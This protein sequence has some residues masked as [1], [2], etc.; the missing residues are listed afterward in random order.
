MV[1]MVT[2]NPSIARNTPM[3]SL[4]CRGSNFFS[5][6]RRSFSL[7]ARIIARMCGKRSSAK[8]MC[9]VRQS[10]MPSAPNARAWMASRGMSAFARTPRVR[11]GS[12]QPMN[13]SSSGSSG[14]G[15]S[16]FSW[17]LITRPVVPSSEIQ[18]PS[19]NTWP[20]TRIS[21]F[22]SST[23]MSPAPATQHFPMPRV[24]TAAWLVMPPR[25]VRMP[26]ATSMPWMSSGVV[27]ARTRM[28]GIFLPWPPSRLLRQR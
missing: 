20:L 1:R 10:P 22:F 17:P 15:G 19:L 11:N 3:K 16:V 5:A 28:T 13:L 24:T 25:E 27:S 18:S 14:L 21:R 23:S 4:R 12:A 8:N 6:A 26:F 9:S 7:F 2:G